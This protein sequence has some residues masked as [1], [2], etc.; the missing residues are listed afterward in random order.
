MFAKVLR[1]LSGTKLTKPGTFRNAEGTGHAV[2]CS[3]KV[4][5]CV[6]LCGCVGEGGEEAGRCMLGGVRRLMAAGADGGGPPVGIWCASV[7]LRH[8]PPPVALP[9]PSPLIARPHLRPSRP[10]ADDG[11]LYPLE[12]AFFYV[13]KPPLLLV[14]DD[15]DCVEFLRQAAGATSAK[16]FDLAVR[17]KAGAVEYLFRGIPRCGRVMVVVVVVGGDM[18]VGGTAIR[19]LSCTDDLHASP[20]PARR[21]GLCALFTGAAGASG[22]TCSS[23]SRPSSCASRTSRRRS[24]A[25]APR[26]PT[27]QTW[28]RR[29][30][31]RVRCGRVVCVGGWVDR[32]KGCTGVTLWGRGFGDLVGPACSAAVS[33]VGCTSRR[34]IVLCPACR[35]A[36]SAGMAGISAGRDSEDEG[37]EDF[38]ASEE[39]S[40]GEGSSSEEDEEGDAEMVDEGVSWR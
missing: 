13:Q 9:S 26:W 21:D 11:F 29:T 33:W 35:T 15:I 10:Q 28:A 39:E 1:G 25:P 18:W 40:E 19:A 24:A 22:P 14:H 27:T 34:L 23:S 7:P 6:C 38:Q 3:Y 5:V 32:V 8:P 16:T 17:M 20:G 36:P 31:T 30:W 12:R 2:R 4:G 37:D